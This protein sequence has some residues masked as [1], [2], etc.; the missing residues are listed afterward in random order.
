MHI[1]HKKFYDYVKH[2]IEKL[3]IN[4]TSLDKKN[5]KANLAIHA[6]VEKVTFFRNK[7]I[8]RVF[9]R[10]PVTTA[11]KSERSGKN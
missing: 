4:V 5:Q 2:L 8:H 3:L 11:P 1:L 9:L 10:L 7:Q 6:F